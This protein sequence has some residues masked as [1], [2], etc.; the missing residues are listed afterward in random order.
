MTYN[1]RSQNVTRITVSH[2]YLVGNPAVYE[3]QTSA[4]VWV[5]E[6]HRVHPGGGDRDRA[7]GHVERS[8]SDGSDY[9]ILRHRAISDRNIVRESHPPRQFL[10]S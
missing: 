6:G 2:M 9:R 7:G 1:Y 3:G 8:V 10:V 4:V 5:G